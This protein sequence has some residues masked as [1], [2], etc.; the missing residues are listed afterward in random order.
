LGRLLVKRAQISVADEV[1][2]DC[3][4]VIMAHGL[5]IVSKRRSDSEFHD[6]T[7]LTVEGNVLPDFCEGGAP[8]V[9]VTCT[10]D[11][12]DGARHT[13]ISNIEP[14]PTERIPIKALRN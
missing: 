4:P 10:V 1:L 11:E 9:V 3:E 12:V 6:Y 7:M 13:R 14:A 2:A 8:L 5:T